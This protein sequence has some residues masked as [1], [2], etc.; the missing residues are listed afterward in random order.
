MDKPAPQDPENLPQT[1]QELSTNSKGGMLIVVILIVVL[2]AIAFF[3]YTKSHKKP[4]NTN[5][6]AP[7][8]QQSVSKP[9]ASSEDLSR[10]DSSLDALDED[11]DNIDAGFSDTQG[12]L[13]EE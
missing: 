2:A 3:V 9:D 8:V 1:F 6:P 12:D 11:L 5:S 10:L 4:A 13:T 7:Q